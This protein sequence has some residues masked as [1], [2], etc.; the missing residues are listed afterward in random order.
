VREQEEQ[1]D[2]APPHLPLRDRGHPAGHDPMLGEKG[3]GAAVVG[4]SGA[5]THPP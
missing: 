5:S 1:E 4:L 3:G 2:K